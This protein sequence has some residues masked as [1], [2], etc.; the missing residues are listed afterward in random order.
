MIRYR[1]GKPA[2]DPFLRAAELLGRDPVRCLVIEDAPAGIEGAKAA[3]ATVLALRTTHGP[4][5]LGQADH[6]T[7]DLADVLVSDAEGA[8]LVSWRSPG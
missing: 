3:G 2:P 1:L 4:E 7:R 5:D 6:Q 8:L